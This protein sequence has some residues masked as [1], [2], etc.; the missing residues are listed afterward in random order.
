MKKFIIIAI[1][2]VLSGCSQEFG[3][4]ENN[5]SIDK[6]S[7]KL[8]NSAKAKEKYK[9]E[10]SQLVFEKVFNSEKD[11]YKGENKDEIKVKIGDKETELLGAGETTFNPSITLERWNEVSFKINPKNLLNS[12]VLLG[13]DDNS[14]L[15]FV[16]EK[17]EYTSSNIDIEMFATEDGEAYKY[18][19]YLNS[20]P[21][22]NKFEF[23]IETNGLDFFY[24]APLNEEMAG[25][26]CWTATCTPTQCCNSERPE[27][28]V[29]SYAV[30]HSSK[31]GMN[32]INGKDYN[33]GKA[34]HIYRP[35][36]IDA[37]GNETWGI[38]N[39]NIGKGLYT[40][41]IPQEF[42]DE[43][44][45]PVKS[46]DTIGYTTAGESSAY[47]SSNDGFVIKATP[48]S[49]GTISKHTAYLR[50]S[51]G[52]GTADFNS[53]LRLYSDTSYLG[54]DFDSSVNMPENTP[55][56]YD[57]DFTTPVDSNSI[58]ADTDYY[59]GAW[60][61][62]Y[63]M[64]C[65]FD[66]GESG[67]GGDSNNGIADETITITNTD[68][69]YSIYAT[70]SPPEEEGED[71]CTYSGSGVWNVLYSD[72]C[73]A[74]TTVTLDNDLNIIRDGAGSFTINDGVQI[75]NS[76]GSVILEGP[77]NIEIEDTANGFQI[78]N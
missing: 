73:F 28:V 60:A 35:H 14:S 31:G 27:N 30:Y 69:K 9:L 11:K 34:F 62:Q 50:V 65:Y 51:N 49:S 41:E 61:G 38:L 18:V 16:D 77:L 7:E 12:N 2:I 55:G 44:V 22:K 39:I 5:L 70:Y 48:F 32:D 4:N 36:I 46:N 53:S 74:T 71:T 21:D 23:E 59:V 13:G 64:N 45:Y 8:E 26:D 57:S 3:A 25:E 37:E 1:L 33:V 68:R 76:D 24:Q 58:T 54:R 10:K 47:K 52:Y 40:I 66:D 6:I 15:D 29:G 72:D 67:D 63:G 17:V 43:A 42:L 75:K 56:W 19:W 20:K 78:D